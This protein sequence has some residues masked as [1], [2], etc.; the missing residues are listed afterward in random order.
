MF[1]SV[2]T[3]CKPLFHK[4][5]EKRYFIKWQTM[6][7]EIQCGCPI[8]VHTLLAVIS[9]CDGLISCLEHLSSGMRFP[10]MWYV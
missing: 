10:Q 2:K 5:F 4:I 9:F 7:A 6:Q 3:S 1:Y 8:F